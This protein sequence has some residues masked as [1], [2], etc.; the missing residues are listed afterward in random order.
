MELVVSSRG[1][2]F[3]V[4]YDDCDHELISGFKWNI[5]TNKT[6]VSYARGSEIGNMKNRV[7]MHRLIMK[8]S[9]REVLIDHV[10]GNGLDNRRLNLRE[11][12][13]RQNAYNSKPKIGQKY[14]G[15]EKSGNRWVPRLTWEGIR[16]SLGRFD[17]EEEAA[18]VYDK[19]AAKIYGDFARI[20]R[21]AVKSEK[22]GVA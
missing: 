8:P 21:L 5:Q 3:V 16:F 12:T 7:Y 9:S 2:S 14:K 22:A 17:T 20:N 19:V 11:C 10:D 6:G 18:A 13:R 1:R 4:K 15:I